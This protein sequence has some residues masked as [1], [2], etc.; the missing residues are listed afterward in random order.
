MKAKLSRG[1]LWSF[2]GHLTVFSVFSFSFGNKMPSFD[3]TAVAF[4]G[5][6]LNSADLKRPLLRFGFRARQAKTVPADKAAVSSLENSVES[7]GVLLLGQLKP[8]ALLPV[9]QEKAIFVNKPPQII[10]EKNEPVIV[11]YPRLPQS[12]ILYFQDRQTV[13][14]EL[15]FNIS[16]TNSIKSIAVQRKISSGN[17]EADLLSARYISR[18]LFMQQSRFPINNWQTVKIDLSTKN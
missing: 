8:Q 10:K 4:R 11:F 9:V 6:I 3:Y 12:F 18:Y 2:V 13:H 15:M 17:L 14:I 1:V 5:E 7:K 16:A